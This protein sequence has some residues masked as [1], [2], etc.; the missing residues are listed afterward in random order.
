MF[1]NFCLICFTAVSYTHLDSR[2]A[3]LYRESAEELLN[4]VQT[5]TAEAGY[6]TYI[7][8]PA[9]SGWQTVALIGP[10]IEGEEPEPEP[11]PQEYYAD[12]QAPAQTA[13]GSFDLTFTVNTCLLYTSGNLCRCHRAVS[14]DRR[15]FHGAACLHCPGR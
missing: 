1:K 5:Y 6:Y 4:G 13:G 9:A 7:Y 11:V 8:Q 10:A 2:A 14:A 12:W 3:A 15:G